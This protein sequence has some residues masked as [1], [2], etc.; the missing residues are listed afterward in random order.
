MIT[1]TPET[2]SFETECR[3]LLNGAKSLVRAIR[4]R[5][6]HPDGLNYVD[7]ETDSLEETIVN[8]FGL[9]HRSPAAPAM[10]EPSS[11]IPAVHSRRHIGRIRHAAFAAA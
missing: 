5:E 3:I 4:N 9:E 11:S 10:N 7:K 6:R 2:P 1:L 8:L